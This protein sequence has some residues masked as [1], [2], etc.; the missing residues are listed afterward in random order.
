MTE[1]KAIRAA[2]K[3]ATYVACGT[4]SV[5]PD[6]AFEFCRKGEKVVGCYDVNKANK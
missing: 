3:A 5:P 1:I 6:S 4:P 2:Q